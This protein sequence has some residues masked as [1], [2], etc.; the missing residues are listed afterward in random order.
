MI[1]RLRLAPVVRLAFYTLAFTLCA[2]LTACTSISSSDGASDSTYERQQQAMKDPMG[3]SPYSKGDKND[4]SG[5]AINNFD[6][7]GMKRDL[8]TVFNP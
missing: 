6:K 7:E 4:V 3:Y 5:G 2:T 8:D 1:T